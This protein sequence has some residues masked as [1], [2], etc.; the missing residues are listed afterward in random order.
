MSDFP[1]F[2]YVST[3]NDSYEVEVDAQD[4]ETLRGLKGNRQAIYDWLVIQ[5]S[6]LPKFDE[7]VSVDVE[8]CDNPQVAVCEGNETIDVWTVDN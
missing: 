3:E 2:A 5:D 4:V 7:I 6:E 1:L 8:L